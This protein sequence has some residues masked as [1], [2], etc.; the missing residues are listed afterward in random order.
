MRSGEVSRRQGLNERFGQPGA[1][2][3]TLM[4]VRKEVHYDVHRY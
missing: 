4:T 1:N 3:M 2:A